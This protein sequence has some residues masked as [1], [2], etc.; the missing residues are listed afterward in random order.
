MAMLGKLDDALF[1][2]AESADSDLERGNYFDAI[3]ELRLGRE[4]IESRFIDKLL[5]CWQALERGDGPA[6]R[7]LSGQDRSEVIALTAAVRRAETECADAL[8]EVRD[9]LAL[10]V[11]VPDGDEI[12]GP[13][14]VFAAFESASRD[15]PA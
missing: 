5:A 12:I 10:A 13:R 2:L 4:T 3:R 9:G 7:Q 11:G 14:Q 15:T 6:Q 8:R 1:G